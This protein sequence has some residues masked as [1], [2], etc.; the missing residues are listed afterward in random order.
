MRA[1]R[2]P[3]N[4]RLLEP[5]A[6]LGKPRS[7]R[8]GRLTSP[9]LR[10]PRRQASI[11]IL[12]QAASHASRCRQQR[13]L[14]SPVQFSCPPGLLPTFPS[15]L[16]SFSQPYPHRVAPAAYEPHLPSTRGPPTSLHALLHHSPVSACTSA[17]LPPCRRP[18]LARVGQHSSADGT[19]P[20]C[21]NPHYRRPPSSSPHSASPSILHTSRTALGSLHT[22]LN[23]SPLCNT[24]SR[25]PARP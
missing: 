5:L 23:T 10:T 7:A 4:H 2:S 1:V 19:Y 22:W 6:L 8:A 16:P 17:F 9:L 20:H 24:H 13:P 11:S 15:K 12:K 25:Q 14:Q 3:R 21:W 18:R